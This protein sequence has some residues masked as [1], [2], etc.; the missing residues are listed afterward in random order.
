MWQWLERIFGLGFM[1]HGHCYLWSPEMVWTQVSANLLIGLAYASIAS[2]LAI[3][4]RKIRNIPFAWVYLAFGTFILSCGL[5][6]FFDI[7]TVWHPIY[8]ADAGVRAVT[9]TASVATALLI[10]PMVPKAV[11]F[12][13][14]ARLSIDRGLQLEAAHLALEKAH[15]SLAERERDAQRRA[16]TSEEQLRSLVETMPQMSWIS[17]ARGEITFRNKRW[18]EYT[19]LSLEPD[20]PGWRDAV[21]PDTASRLY[22]DWGEALKNKHPFEIEAQFRRADGEYR[23]FLA[24]AVALFDNAG[25]VI[26]WMGT[27][28]DI[29]DQKTLHE[30][31]LHTARMKDEFLATVSHELRTPL[32]A[33]LGWSRVL[34]NGSL[35]PEQREKALLSV[36]RN[37]VA[38]ARLVDD[39]LDVSRMVSGKMRIE[40]ALMN[41]ADAVEAALDAVRPAAQAKGVELSAEIDRATGKVLADSGRVQ[42]IVWNLTGN[43]VKFTPKGGHVRVKIARVESQIEISV[44]DDGTGIKREFLAHL[45]QRFTQEDGS[46]RRNHGGLGLGLAISKHLVELHG[47]QIRVES[48][49]PGLGATFTMSLPLA[50]ASVHTAPDVPPV[51]QRP[52][53]TGD[54]HGLRGLRLLLVEDDFDSSEVVSAILEDSGVQVTIADNAEVALEVLDHQ[55]IDVILSDVGLPGKDGYAFIKAVRS[56]ASSRAIPAAALTAYA[57]AEDR[58]RALDA[59]FQM[60]LRKPFDQDELFTVIGDLAKLSP[61][62]QPASNG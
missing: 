2:T 48:P 58:R 3:L 16:S 17:N 57:H 19:G 13:E 8:W 11:S 45:F 32:N 44:A 14:A 50:D 33:I 35:G 51:S 34:V 26:S 38:Q 41:P 60:H 39:L 27:C 37:A 5:T 36:E 47:G 46:I 54:E 55:T 25:N 30:E 20:D 40:P 6:H 56:K 62:R 31:A 28:T 4:V 52:A 59:G 29:H 24:R 9:A 42:Q 15:A 22:S 18:R 43:A 12:A 53:K 10:V 23:W 21:H 49:G 7:I 61:T 1:P